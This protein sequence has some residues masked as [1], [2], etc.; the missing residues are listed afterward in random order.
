[1]KQLMHFHKDENGFITKCY[2]NCKMLVTNWQF[3]AGMTFS[4]PFEHFLWEKVWPFY[5]IND[6]LLK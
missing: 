2:H 5:I 6:L 1:M 3:W 4:F